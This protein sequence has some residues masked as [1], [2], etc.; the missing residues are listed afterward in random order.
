M[1]FLPPNKQCQ[2]TENKLSDNKNS[3]IATTLYF[4]IYWSTWVIFLP[5]Q[6]EHQLL[7]RQ[8]SLSVIIAVN[9]TCQRNAWMKMHK[10]CLRNAWMKMHAVP[11]ACVDIKAHP[12]SHR[13]FSR[14]TWDRSFPSRFF[15]HLFKKRTFGNKLQ[16]FFTGQMSFLSRHSRYLKTIDLY[17][18]KSPTSQCSKFLSVLWDCWWGDRKG[19]RP[20]NICMRLIPKSS[21]V[22]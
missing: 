18:R 13:S 21:L 16:R 3:E 15:L 14:W 5:R 22:E 10:T 1:P 4:I 8:P 17:Q 19:I 12:P 9:K 20:T 6:E 7:P 2:S 11:T